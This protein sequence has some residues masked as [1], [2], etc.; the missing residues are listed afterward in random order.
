[1]RCDWFITAIEPPAQHPHQ[2]LSTFTHLP[3]MCHRDST[4]HLTRG[5]W[6]A[7]T[8]A[9]R[10]NLDTANVDNPMVKEKAAIAGTLV[11]LQLPASCQSCNIMTQR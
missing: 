7:G 8:A 5:N 11:P 4:S 3:T 9:P 1:M 10:C 6:H 2:L